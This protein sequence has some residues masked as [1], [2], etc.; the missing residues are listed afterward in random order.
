MTYHENFAIAIKV[1][2]KILREKDETVSIPFGTEYSILIKN[3]NSK[4]ALINIYIDGSNIADENVSGL[5]INANETVEIERFVSDNHKFKFIEKTEEISNY[6]GDKIDD[7]IVRVEYQ[8]EK[9]KPEK[10][11]R[12]IEEYHTYTNTN[13]PPY[14]SDI[15]WINNNSLTNDS[16]SSAAYNIRTCSMNYNTGNSNNSTISAASVTL[17]SV[18]NSLNN[19]QEFSYNDDKN[20]DGITVKGSK[21]EQAFRSTDEFELEENS[22]VLSLKLKGYKKINNKEIDITKPVYVKTKI[23]CPTCGHKNKSY[24]KFCINCGTALD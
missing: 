16:S 17:D 7:G 18:N 21:S 12:T 22:Y 5:V 23:T 6:R 1:N 24:A 2:G 14:H 8:F 15:V 13:W 11:I 9:N 20:T 19:M 3:L 4:R 10:V